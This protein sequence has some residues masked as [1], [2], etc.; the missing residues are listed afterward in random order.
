LGDY[1]I[2]GVLGVGGMGKV[3]R[4]VHRLMGREVAIKVMREAQAEDVSASRRFEREVRALAQLSHPNIV[5]AYDAREEHG[6]VYLVTELIHGEDLAK[7]VARKGPLKPRDAMYYAWQA[8]KGLHYAH[9]QGIIHRDIKPGNLI[10]EN[11]RTIKVLDLGLARSATSDSNRADVEPSLTHPDHFVGTARYMA[12]EQA[13]SPLKADHRADIYSLGCTLYFLLTGQVPYSGETAIE[14]VMA[15]WQQPI[16]DLPTQINQWEL[17]DGLRELTYQMMAKLPDDRPQSMDEV[18]RRLD[19]LLRQTLAATATTAE[20]STLLSGATLWATPAATSPAGRLGTRSNWSR[21]LGNWPPWAWPVIGSGGIISLGLVFWIVS[22]WWSGTSDT[23]PI[24]PRGP[25]GDQAVATAPSN[26]SSNRSANSGQNPNAP[27]NNSATTNPATNPAGASHLPT[28]SADDRNRLDAVIAAGVRFNGSDSYV[29]VAR[30]DREITGPF[31]LEV[32]AIPQRQPQSANLVTWACEQI[33]ALFLLPSGQWG[34]AFRD[35]NLSRL[36]ITDRS[37]DY[38][39]LVFV[40]GQWD[41]EQLQIWVNGQAEA[42]SPIQY[43]LMSTRPAL[44]FGGYPTDYYPE[45]QG[46]RFFQGQIL[47]V[48]IQSQGTPAEWGPPLQR[49]AAFREPVVVGQ[50]IWAF[51]EGQGDIVHD[52]SPAHWHGQLHNAPW[53]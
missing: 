40:T 34:I 7:R 3:Y 52:A 1:Q 8:A 6:L 51:D 42:V 9:Q 48:R 30:F 15:H 19:Q 41:G 33:A 38:G 17:P 10:L 25:S 12:P 37:F 35:G 20:E 27:T 43:D 26:G 50:W 39:Q 14:T 44:F 49:L 47:G 11:K 32:A 18:V 13:R 31:R 46:T 45:V 4:A 29:S 23:P 21:R 2:V 22:S 16:P 36:M 53:Q 24:V 28:R 5:T